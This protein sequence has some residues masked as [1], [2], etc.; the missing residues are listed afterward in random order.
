MLKENVLP[1]FFECQKDRRTALPTKPRSLVEKRLRQEV[2]KV[3]EEE[4]V[5]E[6][7]EEATDV[8][9]DKSLTDKLNDDSENMKDIGVQVNLVPRYRSVRT[10]VDI[11]SHGPILKNTAC[12]PIKF[13]LSRLGSSSDISVSESDG[14]TL[15]TRKKKSSSSCVP[16]D[17]E[18]SEI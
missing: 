11:P 7:S 13:R 15:E 3:V 14:A 12:S 8:P 10:Q 2:L 6:E 16:S 5:A 1:R 18:N 17:E 4:G 9:E